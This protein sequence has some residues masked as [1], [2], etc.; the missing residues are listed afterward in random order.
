MDFLQQLQNFTKGD[1]QQGKW[2]IGLA[3]V[4]LLPLAFLLFKN[5][6]SLQKG[7]SIPFFL[8][9]IINV[10]YGGYV[11][12]SKPKHLAE[13]EQQFQANP[14]QTLDSE[15]QKVKADDKSYSILKYVWGACAVI[16]IAIYFI[17]SKDYYKGLSLGFAGLFFGFLLIDSFFHQRLKLYSEILQGSPH[18]D[19][20][21]KILFSKAGHP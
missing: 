16:F 7:M 2:M 13:T 6:L 4:I 21:Y 15:L 14:P 9:F 12:Y 10:G 1:M 11:L 8:L 18:D 17:I 3:V 20:K 5:S 19:S